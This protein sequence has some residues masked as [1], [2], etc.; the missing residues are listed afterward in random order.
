MSTTHE[1]RQRLVPGY[2]DWVAVAMF[3]LITVD[4]LTTLFAAAS[5]GAG[6]ESNPVVAWL[7][8]QPVWLV[9][10][11]NLAAVVLNGVFFYALDEAMHATP[12][13]YDRYFAAGVELWL[14]SLIAVGLFVFANNLVVI[15]HGA[16]LV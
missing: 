12:E 14:G 2:W 4:L 9:V 8:G 1:T 13:P 16:S 5:Y 6:A 11:V 10:V 3:L 7:L 15:V